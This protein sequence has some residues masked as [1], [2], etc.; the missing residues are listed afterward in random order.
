MRKGKELTEEE[1]AFIV[2]TAKGR[3][4]ITKIA[5]ETKRPKDTIA[6]IPLHTIATW[7]FSNCETFCKTFHNNAKR[8]KTFNKIGEGGPK[9]TS[10]G[11]AQKVGSNDQENSKRE[12]N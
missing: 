5:A 7:T 8:W 6:T 10:K 4:S 9:G 12:D 11:F 1:R 3:V 2:G